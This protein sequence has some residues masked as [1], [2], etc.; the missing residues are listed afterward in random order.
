MVPGTKAQ[1]K[2]GIDCNSV[3]I[4]TL[5]AMKRLFAIVGF[6]LLWGQSLQCYTASNSDLPGDEILS[7][8]VDGADTAWIG[9]ANGLTWYAHPNFRSSPIAQSNWIAECVKAPNAALWCA[10]YNLGADGGVFRYYNG[11]LQWYDKNDIAPGYWRA[12]VLGR[13]IAMEGNTVWVGLFGSGLAK[14]DGSSWT[15]YHPRITTGMPDSTINAIAIDAQGRKW[16]GTEYRSVVLFD[17]NTWMSLG[18]AGSGRIN[19]ILITSSG[20]VYV[21]ANNGV[22]KYGGSPNNWQQLSSSSANALAYDGSVLW[23]G[24]RDGVAKYD[25]NTFATFLTTADGLPSNSVRSIG[26]SNSGLLYIGTLNRGLCVY[27]LSQSLEWNQRNEKDIRVYPLPAGEYLYLQ[28]APGREIEKIRLFSPDG[29][30]KVSDLSHRQREQGLWLID[31]PHTLPV[32]WYIME[33]VGRGGWHA[34]TKVVK[35]NL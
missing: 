14:Y 15:W 4:F 20:E 8:Y 12:S 5:A 10:Y 6:T 22:Y 17:G 9:T 3:K 13:S 34:Y 28:M 2:P 30:I 1:E 35:E 21:A 23:V 29:G 33:I 18:P 25:G 19:D 26:V 27:Q 32:G 31:L 16:L 11:T 24:L 7:I